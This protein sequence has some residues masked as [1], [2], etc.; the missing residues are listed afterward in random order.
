MRRLLA[1]I[2]VVALATTLAGAVVADAG[3]PPVLTAPPHGSTLARMEASL[4]WDLPAGTT[5][6][7]L[8]VTPSNGDGPGVNLIMDAT[9]AF[10]IPAPPAWYGLLPDMGYTWRV[11]ASASMSAIG[12]NDPSWGPWSEARVFRTPFASASTIMTIDPHDAGS[13]QGQTPVLMWTDSNP[14]TWYYEVQISWDGSFGP[15][16]PLYWEIVHG[17]LRAPERQYAVPDQYP[18][19]PGV[20]YFWRVRPRVQ[21]DGAAVAWSSAWRFTTPGHRRVS[22]EENGKTVLVRV[23]DTVEVG[24]GTGYQWT[25]T[26]DDR[27]VLEPLSTMGPSAMPVMLRAKASGSTRLTATGN[28][29]CHSAQPPCL[30]PS[31]LFEVRVEVTGRMVRETAPIDGAE[32]RRSPDGYVLDVVSGL[33]SGCAQFDGYTTGRETESTVRVRVYNLMPA[34]P[35]TACTMIYGIVSSTIPLPGDFNAGWSYTVLVNDKTVTFT[36]S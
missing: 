16:A 3:D 26:V 20:T 8:Q 10:V 30:A 19:D 12:E 24:L 5:Q 4:T 29:P 9:G 23:G 13:V 6:A 34:D 32:V 15:S 36:A 33:P 2:A 28:L 31:R 17:N 25:V 7:H 35:R 27:N 14:T 11:R 21:G 1:G 22:L 18:L